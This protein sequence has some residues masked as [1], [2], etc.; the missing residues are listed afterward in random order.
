MKVSHTPEREQLFAEK[1]ES[2]RYTLASELIREGRRRLEDQDQLKQQR[3]S[4]V[5]RKI[6]RGLKQLDD[7]L[8]LSATKVRARLRRSRD[9]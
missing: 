7:G 8:G 2:G 5:R 6:D 3:F 1:V 9:E 4:E